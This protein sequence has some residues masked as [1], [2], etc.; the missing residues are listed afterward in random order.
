LLL[1]ALPFAAAAGTRPPSDLT[2]VLNFQGAHSDRSVNEMKRET[3][4][5][6]RTSGLRLDWR[7]SGE[8]SRESYRDLVVVRFQGNCHVAPL[9]RVYDEL[10]PLAFSYSADGSVQPFSQVDCDKVAASVRS[11]LWGEDFAKADVLLGRALGR[12]LVHELVHMLTQSGR[13]T[14]QG[15]EQP[16]LSG[17]QLVGASLRLGPADL[18]LLRSFAAATRP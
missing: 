15:V 14:K 18:E 17:K 5:I 16:A 4:E 1:V 11:A 3:E 2:V 8:A 9:P 13:H 10:G 6:L 7:L 12:V